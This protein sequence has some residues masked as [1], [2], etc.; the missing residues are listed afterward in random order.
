MLT[1]EERESLSQ[2][3]SAE[4][5]ATAIAAT[6]PGKAPG[7]DS[8]T[9]SC[10]GAFQSILTP[11]FLEAFNTITYAHS[12]PFEL[13]SA[14]ISVILKPGKRPLQCASFRSISL[15]NCDVK[16]FTKII[17]VRLNVIMQRIVLLDQV[18]FIQSREARDNIIRTLDIIASA[19]KLNSPLL[20]S[21]DAE[22]AF[23]RV[24]WTFL[25]ETLK[26]FGMLVPI[27]SWVSAIYANPT[28]TI[29]VNGFNSNSL[30]ISHPHFSLYSH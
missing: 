26:C 19:K 29:R 20:L 21:T 11:Y 9:L 23:K 6:Q 22:K 18:G 1:Q 7:P 27:L 16:L 4:E 13:L 10:Y 3:L 2:P 12:T 30:V 15:F 25:F 8:F 28:A 5:F 17:A 24:N 14:N